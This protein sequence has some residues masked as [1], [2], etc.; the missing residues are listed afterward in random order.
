MDYVLK[1][2]QYYGSFSLWY[3]FYSVE[4]VVVISSFFEAAVNKICLEAAVS[5]V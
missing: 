3:L 2:F 1:Q 5:A 4:D